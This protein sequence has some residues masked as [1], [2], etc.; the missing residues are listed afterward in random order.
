[1]LANISKRPHNFTSCS[2]M[3][4]DVIVGSAQHQI[5][6]LLIITTQVTPAAVPKGKRLKYDLCIEQDFRRNV[7]WVLWENKY[8]IHVYICTSVFTIPAQ[9]SKAF[10]LQ[11]DEKKKTDESCKGYCPVLLPTRA[12]RELCILKKWREGSVSPL[13]LAPWTQQGFQGDRHYLGTAF[14]GS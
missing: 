2:W 8:N 9:P 7:L 3:L 12:A 4:F 6:D 1:M 14:Q 5:A 11:Q 13:G 10:A